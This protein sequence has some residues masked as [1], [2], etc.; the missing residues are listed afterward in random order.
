MYRDLGVL[1]LD[2]DEVL[3]NIDIYELK[4]F[5]NRKEN[6]NALDLVELKPK[7]FKAITINVL[8]GGNYKTFFGIKEKNTNGMH[9]FTDFFY[10]DFGTNKIKISLA[11]KSANTLKN[12]IKPLIRFLN[13]IYGQRF[14][15]I[16][17]LDKD[18]IREFLNSYAYNLIQDDD[19]SDSCRSKTEVNRTNQVITKFAYWLYTARKSA[20]SRELK[21][22]MKYFEF[23]DFRATKYSRKLKNGGIGYKYKLENIVTVNLDNSSGGRIRSK[24]TKASLYTV[25][26]LVEVSRIIDPMI[27]FAIVLDAFA[28]LRMGEVMQMHNGRIKL[29]DHRYE[30][31][32]LYIDLTSDAR[33]R[34]DRVKT[35]EIKINRVQPVFEIFADIIRDEYINQQEL[36]KQRG[37]L[38]HKYGAFFINEDGKAMTSDNYMRRFKSIAEQAVINIKIEAGK[39]NELGIREERLLEGLSITPHSLRHIYSQ[40]LKDALGER[41]AVAYYRGDSSLRSQD[42]YIPQTDLRKAKESFMSK[43]INV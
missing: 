36:L 26:K 39:G 37:F 35:G 3:D 20:R 11:D 18:L 22:K 31:C 7:N 28:G 40:F 32:S 14:K 23:D 5:L 15:G 4:S 38:M 12:Y 21:Y 1:D 10:D 9:D 33:L 6:S 41:A 17:G 25:K 27:T 2:N 19:K 34:S 43:Y 16:G 42:T 29:I 13:Y 8:M 30:S 24:V